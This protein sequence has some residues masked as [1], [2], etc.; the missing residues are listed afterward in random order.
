M[1]REE[2]EKEGTAH[3]LTTVSSW[4]SQLLPRGQVMVGK[5]QVGTEERGSLYRAWGLR[6][7]RASASRFRVTVAA[8]DP[9]S[10]CPRDLTPR[11]P[12]PQA[13][14]YLFHFVHLR[15][16]ERAKWNLAQLPVP[17]RPRMSPPPAHWRRAMWPGDCPPPP[18]PQLLLLLP[19]PG[20]EGAGSWGR[21]GENAEQ[22]A[23]WPGGCG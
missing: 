17:Q 11:S 3:H 8:K 20:E 2:E 7:K 21:R 6:A 5:G 12:S 18:A 9:P 15:G 14:P 22:G 19:F 1:Q 4:P 16:A 13:S 23:P 10:L